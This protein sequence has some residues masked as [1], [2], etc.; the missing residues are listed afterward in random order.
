MAFFEKEGAGGGAG[1]E[2]RE[3]RESLL[4]AL[5]FFFSFFLIGRSSFDWIS[6]SRLLGEFFVI[7]SR[8]MLRY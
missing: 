3:R 7:D 6:F 8:L 1:G 5:P 4:N 2:E